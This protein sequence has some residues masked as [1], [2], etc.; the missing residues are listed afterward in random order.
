VRRLG[1][2]CGALD[3]LLSQVGSLKGGKWVFE[4]ANTLI[5]SESK[6]NQKLDPETR[7]RNFFGGTPCLPA[8]AERNPL[9]APWCGVEAPSDDMTY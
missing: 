7:T 6:Q 9:R 1:R 4:K 5:I 2:T 3:S 8:A